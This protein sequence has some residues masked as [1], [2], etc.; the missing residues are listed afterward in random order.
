MTDAMLET[1]T[2]QYLAAQPQRVEFS[3]QGGETLL[4]GQELFRRAFALQRQFAQP[5]QQITNALQ[6]NGTLL[7]ESWCDLFAESDVL[8][9]VSL[10]GP[11]AWHD[12]FRRDAA[13]QGSF[14]RAWA[15]IELLRRRGVQFNVLVT[16]NSRN[17]AQAGDL[18][19]YFVNRGIGYLQFIP[20]LERDEAGRPTDFS[21]TPELF[22]RF[23]V[24]VF[25]LWRQRYV[26]VVS[27]RLIDSVLHTLVYGT[28]AMCCHAPRCANAF[29]LEWNGDLYAC[30]HFV[31]ERFRLGN[32]E[33]T[34]LEELVVS[35]AV[36]E[37]AR[38]KTELPAACRSC[39]YL[40]FCQGGCP[41]HHTPPAETL[42]PAR[43]N[44]FCAAYKAF[45]AEALGE[46][47]VMAA[48]IKAGRPA[49]GRAP[50]PAPRQASAAPSPAPRS[51]ATAPGRNDPCPCGSGR[52]FKH[53]CRR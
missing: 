42:D 8:L 21:C 38:L 50:A 35:P 17:A 11:P 29:V 18:F 41:K 43:T 36:E 28:A 12:H 24:D 27:E 34:P 3:W 23:C 52:K 20:I 1:F 46:L 14:D 10:D 16:L 6:T 5:G 47:T 15:G 40:R 53:C 48:D 33:R 26:G 7:D 4:A 51:S 25:R 39:E 2:R 49:Q 32:I 44:Y 45:F 22:G 19:R 31:F 9:G 37:F 30:D 13:G